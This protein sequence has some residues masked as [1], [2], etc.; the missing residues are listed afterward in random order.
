MPEL[1]R[2]IVTFPFD[3]SCTKIDSPLSN[4]NLILL[5]FLNILLTLFS[6]VTDLV[7]LLFAF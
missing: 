5:E 7:F 4:L 1:Q 3:D 2:I 6:T